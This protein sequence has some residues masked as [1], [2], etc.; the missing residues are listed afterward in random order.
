[1]NY[2]HKINN[3]LCQQNDVTTF[4][5]HLL[6]L[7]GS[8]RVDFGLQQ[9]WPCFKERA[10]LTCTVNEKGPCTSSLQCLET[11]HH[12][13]RA[14][15]ETCLSASPRRRMK[16]VPSPDHP[17]GGLHSEYTLLLVY[18]CQSSL[19]V[20]LKQP[21]ALDSINLNVLVGLQGATKSAVNVKLKCTAFTDKLSQS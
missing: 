4:Q 1:M 2:V 21:F 7:I 6:F 18:E 5:T 10:H 9:Q 12:S 20:T 14:P 3:E 13:R 11:Y 8:V 17:T 19:Q 16:H 15:G